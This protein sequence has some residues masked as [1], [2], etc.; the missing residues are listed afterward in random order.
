V[1]GNEE[2]ELGEKLGVAL[3]LLAGSDRVVGSRGEAVQGV[4]ETVKRK[5]DVGRELAVLESGVD[6]GLEGL[7]KSVDGDLSAARTNG[8]R[9]GGS[10]VAA[11]RESATEKLEDCLEEVVDNA[12]DGADGGKL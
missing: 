8:G 4:D 5:G 11:N 1:A 9:S 2:I 12:D 6:L 7:D 10:N 3:D